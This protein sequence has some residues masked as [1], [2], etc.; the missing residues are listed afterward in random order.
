MRRETRNISTNFSKMKASLNII[1]L[2]INDHKKSKVWSF[3]YKKTNGKAGN[4]YKQRFHGFI[5][6]KSA[7]L[8]KR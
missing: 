1:N 3:E 7:N 6:Q 2:N 4:E 8:S 5:K